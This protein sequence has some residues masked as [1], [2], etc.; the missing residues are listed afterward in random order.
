MEKFTKANAHKFLLELGELVAFDT[1]DDKNT[2][3]EAINENFKSQA[4]GGA[5]KNPSY[6]DNEAE[7][8]MHYCRFKQCFMPEADMNMFKG[9]TK[10]ASRLAAKHDYE[11]GKKFAELKDEALKLFT[12]GDY[13][14][15]AEK[16]LEADALNASRSEPSTFDDENLE[17]LRVKEQEK[18]AEKASANEASDEAVETTEEV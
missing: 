5:S 13:T 15:G 8:M 4:G 9:K 3:V 17:Y 12:D 6:M 11:L 2:Y 1:I 7:T 18:E 10:G 16:N 14:G